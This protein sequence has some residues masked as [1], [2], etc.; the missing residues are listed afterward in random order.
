MELPLNCRGGVLLI[1]PCHLVN[2][3][4]DGF[5]T[6]SRHPLHGYILLFADLWASLRP[7][8]LYGYHNIIQITNMN[9]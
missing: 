3:Q 8:Y 9:L 6:Q 7:I 2:S 4:R 1:V 5:F